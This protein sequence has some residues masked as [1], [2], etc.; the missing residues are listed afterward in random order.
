MRARGPEAGFTLVELVV[1]M[2]L[3]AIVLALIVGVVIDM[4]GASER[5]G[6]ESKAQKAAV[7]AAEMLTSDLRAMRAPQREPIFT[8]SADN[9]R[10]LILLDQNPMGLQVHD[11]TFAGPTR[12]T[13]FAE[14][15]NASPSTE[16][17]TWEVIADGALQRSVRPYAP[18]CGNGAVPPLQQSQVMPPPERARASA[19]VTIPTPFRYRSM[20][21][22]T[23][24]TP[25]P[26]ACTT[27]V[28]SS[29]ASE[30]QRD[31]VVGIDMDLRIFVAG[32]VSRGDQELITSASIPSRQ[33]QEYRFAIGCAA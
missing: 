26:D 1:G 33:S 6:T 18:D 29:T 30:I 14:V 27:P 9:L 28:R 17:V 20:V 31:Q 4:L 21:Q 12:V 2:V 10:N 15:V 25:D 7:A 11:L 16:C 24:A 3:G 5:A 22:P 19:A 23:P 32:R 13:F 8:G